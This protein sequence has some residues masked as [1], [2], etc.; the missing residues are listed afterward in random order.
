MKLLQSFKCGEKKSNSRDIYIVFYI[1]EQYKIPN[2]T[3]V[4]E[5]YP[6]SRARG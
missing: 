1:R 4:N 2:T 3:H 5:Q 6:I